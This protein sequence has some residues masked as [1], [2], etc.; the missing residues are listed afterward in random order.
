MQRR[1][2]RGVDIRTLI[3]WLCWCGVL[4]KAGEIWEGG[5]SI[6]HA[7][8]G[9]LSAQGRPRGWTRVTAGVQP[10]MGLLWEGLQKGLAIKGHELAHVH[11]V[12]CRL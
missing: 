8:W 10:M 9:A 4:W 1:G 7:A 5:E 6:S 3:I 12:L 11:L 2:G